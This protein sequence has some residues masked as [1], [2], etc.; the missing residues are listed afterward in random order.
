[1]DSAL[2][3]FPYPISM[4]RS[5]GTIAPTCE[6]TVSNSNARPPREVEMSFFNIASVSS[7]PPSPPSVRDAQQSGREA[8]RLSSASERSASALEP[9]ARARPIAMGDNPCHGRLATS[10]EYR[11]CNT[12]EAGR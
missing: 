9:G 6:T 10:T 8:P 2:A 11:K 7:A 5:R 4:R 3:D 1:M 12:A